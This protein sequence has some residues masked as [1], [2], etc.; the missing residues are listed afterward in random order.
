M[1]QISLPRPVLLLM[2]VI[3]R[4]AAARA[5]T[6]D[7]AVMQFGP[8]C[9]ESQP[10]DF[11]ETE[12]YRTTMGDDLK[13]TFLAFRQLVPPDSLAPTKVLT[14]T[15]E[16]AYAAQHP[17][18]VPRPINLDP[19]LISESKLI[20]ASTKDHAH[21]I[22][23]GQGIYGELT[24]QFRHRAWQPCDWT[25]PDYRR[26]DFQEFFTACREYLRSAGRIQ[27]SSE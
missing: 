17:S 15:A 6:R 16:Q 27:P 8:I 9:L 5:W 2:A 11:I 4:E 12:Y 24:L 7:W 20:L 1:G 25:Y 14:N 13:K 10:F 22:Y 19:G 26:A 3:S 21:R 23:L 18:D